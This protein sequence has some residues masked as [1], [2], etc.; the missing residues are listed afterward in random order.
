MPLEATFLGEASGIWMT[1]PHTAQIS[2]PS[3]EELKFGHVVV[4]FAP[5]APAC[6]ETRLSAPILQNQELGFELLII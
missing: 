5:Q 1:E 3:S 2:P 4:R 6:L